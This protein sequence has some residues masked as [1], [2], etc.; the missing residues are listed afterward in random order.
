MAD[1]AVLT[2][3]RGRPAQFAE[4][5]QAIH[6]TAALDVVL[7]GYVDDDDPD[8]EAYLELA[9]GHVFIADG[10]RQSLSGWTNAAARAA[11]H[12]APYLASLGDDHLPRTA[13][14]DQRLIAAIEAFAGPGMAYG[15][16]LYQGRNLP[17]AWVVSA[18][19]VRELGWM[20]LPTCE[21]MYVDTAVLA[22]GEAAG[23]IAYVP[24]V[25]IE[26]RH[27]LAGK[28]PWDDSYRETN[29][30]VRYAADK[31]AYDAWLAGG[32]ATDAAA[33]K[34]LRYKEERHG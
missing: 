21:H 22:L 2:P 7:I 26:H 19:V 13:G 10:P 20:M 25:V 5:A 11:V 12:A 24:D 9:G 6:A 34:A 28:A 15:N 33:V 1:L 4:L 8:L 32:L 3:T 14:W 30:A 31:A 16:D 18:E 27:P 29:T 17:T 23:R